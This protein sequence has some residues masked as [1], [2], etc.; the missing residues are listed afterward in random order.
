MVTITQLIYLIP[1]QEKSFDEFE[2][3]AIPSISRYNGRLLFRVRPTPSSYLEHQI[4]PPFE[5]HLVEFDTQQDF[6]CFLEDEER[7]RFLH[8]KERSVSATVLIQGTRLWKIV[9]VMRSPCK[10]SHFIKKTDYKLNIMAY[11]NKLASRVR[12]YLFEKNRPC[13]R[14]IYVRRTGLFDQWKN[15]H[16]CRTKQT[17]VSFWRRASEWRFERRGFSPMIMNEK[18]Y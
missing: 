6:E 16:Q 4:E 7:K 18:Q 17:D 13:G 10:R 2:N 5:I 3:I 14:K 15:V 1:G 12:Q 8:L 11:D 9:L